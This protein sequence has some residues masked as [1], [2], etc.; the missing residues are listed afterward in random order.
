M[1]YDFQTDP[2]RSASQ[3]TAEERKT[4]RN[5]SIPSLVE[6]LNLAEQHN[7]SVMFDLISGNDTVWSDTVDVVDAIIK[8]GIAPSLVCVTLIPSMA[9]DV[10]FP[11]SI[12][13]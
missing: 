11:Q 4:A 3:L 1:L 9:F 13:C 7:V 5:Q 10:D 6:L 12:F 2:F 8:S